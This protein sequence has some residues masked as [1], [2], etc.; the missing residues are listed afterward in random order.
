VNRKGNKLLSNKPVHR[1]GGQPGNTNALKHGYY[2]SRFLQVE[3]HDL[4]ALPETGL[5]N[6][7][8]VLRVLAR[9]IF[10]HAGQAQTVEQL[11][12]VSAALGKLSLII[13]SL[14]KSQHL[15]SS[16]PSNAFNSAVDQAISELTHE[17]GLSL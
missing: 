14:L 12:S 17:L 7:V 1:R 2:S 9:R 3:L 15:M 10:E 13:S 11:I 8:A 6:E 5:H 16:S 4:D